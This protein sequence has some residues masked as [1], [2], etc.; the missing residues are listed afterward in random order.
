MASNAGGTPAA[1][2]GWRASAVVTVP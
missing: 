1:T 2:L